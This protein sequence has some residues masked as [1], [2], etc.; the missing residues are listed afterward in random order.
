VADLSNSPSEKLARPRLFERNRKKAHPEN[1]VGYRSASNI[2]PHDKNRF[3]GI[4]SFGRIYNKRPLPT[5]STQ[6]S[7]FLRKCGTFVILS[8]IGNRL[9]GLD[10]WEEKKR[11]KNRD[12]REVFHRLTLKLEG[13]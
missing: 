13:F 9:K 6:I 3:D 1:S 11:V 8:V 10:G 2:P 7:I 12:Q 4:P 5:P